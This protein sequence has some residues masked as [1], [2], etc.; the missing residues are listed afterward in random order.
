MN[1][2]LNNSVAWFRSKDERKESK[3]YSND[4]ELLESALS[5]ENIKNIDYILCTSLIDVGV[6]I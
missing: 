6:E 1:S 5:G 2:K 4:M 3:K